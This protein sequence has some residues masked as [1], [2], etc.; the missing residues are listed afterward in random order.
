MTTKMSVARKM[1]RQLAGETERR[2][3]AHPTREETRDQKARVVD[4]IEYY[5]A[6][7]TG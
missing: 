2:V 3:K 6:K 1:R 4:G 5:V 7:V